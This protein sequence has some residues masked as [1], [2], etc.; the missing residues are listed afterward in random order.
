[1]EY[2]GLDVYKRDSQVCILGEGGEVVLEQRMRTQRE[3]LMELLSKRPKARVLLESSGEAESFVKRVE[4]LAPPGGL[5][6]E[7]APLPCLIRRVALARRLAGILFA[8]M[9]NGTEYR[10]ASLPGQ[11]HGADAWKAPP[12]LESPMRRRHSPPQVE[13]EQKDEET[14]RARPHS[15]AKYYSGRSPRRVGPAPTRGNPTVVPGESNFPMT[16]DEWCS[17]TKA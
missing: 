14:S 15:G 3:R 4:F 12:L 7:V 8:M 13:R 6:A 1:M 5:K 9:R 11:Q 10:V 2:I 16:T 17:C